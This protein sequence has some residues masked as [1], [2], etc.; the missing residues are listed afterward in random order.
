MSTA[1]CCFLVDQSSVSRF[2][3]AR[4]YVADAA[5]HSVAPAEDC[6]GSFAGRAG[7][8]VHLGCG[9]RNPLRR[10]PGLVL[11]TSAPPN[12][13]LQQ[14]KPGSVLRSAGSCRAEG[15]LR[16][17][18]RPDCSTIVTRLGAPAFAAERHVVIRTRLWSRMT[19]AD[20]RWLRL[21]PLPD[22]ESPPKSGTSGQRGASTALCYRCGRRR[23][24]LFRPKAGALPNRAL[25]QTKPGSAF[26]SALG[27]RAEGQLRCPPRPD[28]STTGTRLGAPA[29][30]LNAMSLS[31]HRNV[32]RDA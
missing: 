29:S 26:R 2:G 22:V 18:P 14:T 17:P 28:S 15:Q 3:G 23:A 30:L 27:C 24:T 32:G 8:A 6:W 11:P 21:G 13:A 10:P 7:V 20:R 31:G 9:L 4:V 16:C 12:K 19:A 25:Q 1:T 5:H